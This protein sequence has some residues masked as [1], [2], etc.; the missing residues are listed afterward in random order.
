MASN[1]A[2]GLS[3]P[4]PVLLSLSGLLSPKDG[5][6]ASGASLSLGIAQALLPLAQQDH[7]PLLELMACSSDAQGSFTLVVLRTGLLV[8]FQLSSVYKSSS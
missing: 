7:L 3:T 6:H 4:G 5:Q 2:T 8:Y 1:K